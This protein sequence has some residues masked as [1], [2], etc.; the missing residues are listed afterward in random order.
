MECLNLS[1]DLATS[2]TSNTVDIVLF[3]IRLYA[4][5]M[6]AVT[7]LWQ[8]LMACH[9]ARQKN[10]Q[11]GFP[12]EGSEKRQE[13]KKHLE[14]AMKDH[15]VRMLLDGGIMRCLKS[16]IEELEASS[17]Q[18]PRLIDK[19]TERIC[20][21]HAHILLLLRSLP[22]EAKPAR[23]ARARNDALSYP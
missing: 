8:N 7:F 18:N 16:W 6:S 12:K 14:Q 1:I 10:W 19:N 13:M 17:Q 11:F 9:R 22:L 3:F 20:D 15:Q 23:T 4:R 2:S 21:I 5:V